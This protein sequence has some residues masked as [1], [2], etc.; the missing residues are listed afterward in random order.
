MNKYTWSE[1]LVQL[2]LYGTIAITLNPYN[3]STTAA[4][5]VV[6]C[7][8]LIDLLSSKAITINTESG[9]ENE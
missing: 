4:I 8:V 6:V 2:A 7:I 9:K 1:W 5:V 3:L